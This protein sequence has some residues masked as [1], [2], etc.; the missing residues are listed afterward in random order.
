MDLRVKRAMREALVKRHNRDEF[1]LATKLPP[2]MLK[3]VEDQE[4]IFNE[5]LGKLRS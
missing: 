1:T 3:S 2:R 5:Q 4:N